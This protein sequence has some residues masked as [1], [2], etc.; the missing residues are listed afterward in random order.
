MEF[1]LDLG[2]FLEFGLILGI[3]FEQVLGGLSRLK[4]MP[5]SALVCPSMSKDMSNN[6]INQREAQNCPIV[7]SN[8]K[9][10]CSNSIKTNRNE[11]IRR[12][13]SGINNDELQNLVRVREEA[14]RPIPTSRRR[15]PVPAPRKMGVKQLIR[16]F[17]NNPIPPYRPIPAPRTKK[18]QPVPAPRTRIGEKQ[19]ALK[20][21]KSYEIG[22]KSDR[23]ALVHLKNTR[24]ALS[25]LFGTILNE[26]KGFKCV[27]TLK[28]TFVK[29]KDDDDI[30]K[31]AY[32]NSRAQ[33][34]INPDDFLPSLQLTQQQILNG[35]GVWLS[36]GSGWT[37][38]SI[39]EH[40]INKVNCV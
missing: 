24:L 6:S 14:R 28:V 2:I 20:G 9:I 34:V 12:S 16:F 7:G 21:F 4:A 17:E 35:T 11:L 30:D 10:I 3:R 8:K 1:D 5:L 39:D 27:E 26:I 29:K 33:I 32:F 36:E 23:D 22:L 18:Q 15:I 38:S 37:I 25:R 13:L 40:Y 31:T 19:R